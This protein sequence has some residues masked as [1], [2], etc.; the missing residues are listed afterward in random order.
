ME[1]IPPHTQTHTHTLFMSSHIDLAPVNDPFSQKTQ[2][3]LR[4][5]PQYNLL[6]Q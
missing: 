1:R 4:L 3:K 2:A 5:R 6:N